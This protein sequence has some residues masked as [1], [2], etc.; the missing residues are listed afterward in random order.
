M[1]DKYEVNAKIFKAL[2]DQ[3]RLKI[4]HIL[5]DG[6]RCAC[7]LLNYFNFTQPTLSHHMKVLIDCELVTS[8]KEGTWNHYSLVEE[9]AKE[10]VDFLNEIIYPERE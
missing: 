7:E 1:K 9:N 6:E 4:I 8:R 5:S 2:S 3:N 10:L